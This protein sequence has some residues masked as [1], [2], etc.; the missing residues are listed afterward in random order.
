MRLPAAI[1]TI[2][3]INPTARAPT[4]G[5]V[6]LLKIIIAPSPAKM[7]QM[8]APAIETAILLLL[9]FGSRTGELDNDGGSE[10]ED[11]FPEGG[12]AS[13][14]GDGAEDDAD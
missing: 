14:L 1:I 12:A 11:G 13:T 9:G 8:K 10:D 3:S 2:P 6:M 4:S 7:S 5:D